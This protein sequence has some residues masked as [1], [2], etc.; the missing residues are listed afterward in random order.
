MANESEAGE[1]VR[2]MVQIK[3][4][5]RKANM[6]RT[7]YLFCGI[8]LGLLL[9]GC[10]STS[11]TVDQIWAR[12]GLSG[13]NGAVYFL[14]DNPTSQDDVL[15]S[16]SSDISAFVEIHESVMKENGTMSMEKQEFV[17]LPGGER[18]EFKPGGLHV[19]LINLEE[20]LKSG[21]QFSLTLTFEK[22]GQRTLT[23]PVMEP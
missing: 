23:V 3:S 15:L 12:P 11:M 8:V 21:D 13:G 7:I 19:M 14:I 9:V 5:D 10:G 22:A 17:P 20:D 6:K 2:K 4:W 18:V 1:S 16:A